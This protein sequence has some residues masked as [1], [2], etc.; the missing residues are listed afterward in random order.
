MQILKDRHTGDHCGDGSHRS[1]RSNGQS[2]RS[3][4]EEIEFVRDHHLEEV[5]TAKMNETLKEDEIEGKRR[6]KK[7]S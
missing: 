4:G 2:A 1:R 3:L 7:Q 6:K 5:K